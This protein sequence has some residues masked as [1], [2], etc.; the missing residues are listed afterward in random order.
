MEKM[1]HAPIAADNDFFES[2]NFPPRET[3]FFGELP[4]V[5]PLALDL[6]FPGI[7][8]I[9]ERTQHGT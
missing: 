8:P 1:V 7:R 5:Y 2:S 4:L 6:A 3:L 9:F